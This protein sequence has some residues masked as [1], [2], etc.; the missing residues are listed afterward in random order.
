M[1]VR[2][3]TGWPGDPAT[4]DT[5]VAHTGA[6]VADLARSATTAQALAGRVSVC[7]ACPRL[8]EWR[9]GVAETKRR[10]YAGEQY[11]GR[12]VPGFGP[13]D[14]HILVVGLA[15]G[16]HGA[17]RTGRNFTGDRSGEWLYASLY[18]CGLANQPTAVAADDGLA[19]YGT[20]IIATVRCA[21]PDNKP[22]PA[23]RD[24]CRPWLVR[25]LELLWPTT[26]AVVV[27]GGF[28]WAGL[29]PALRGIGVDVPRPVPKFAHGVE[30]AL[31]DGRTVLGCYHVSQQ[32]TFTGRLTEAMLDAV[33][34]RAA[35]LAATGDQ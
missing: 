33:F 17:N 15:P 9:E 20:R 28:G 31:P 30:V 26:R 7:R 25:E 23:E 1:T 32:N 19:L 6:D 12:P 11:W 35:V 4:S 8:V 18:R 24:T 21:P 29:W 34:T 5:P 14:P 13:P 3:G 16:A 10:A 27:L 2:P 22:T